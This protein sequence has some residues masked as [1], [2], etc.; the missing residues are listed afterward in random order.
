MFNLKPKTMSKIKYPYSEGDDYWTLEGTDEVYDYNNGGVIAVQSCWDD[1]SEDM[2]TKHLMYFNSLDEILKYS[3]DRFNFVKVS[4]FDSGYP[5]IKT[6][7]YFVVD[8][9][10]GKFKKS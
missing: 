8:L 4:C 9:D 1:Q 10:T 2:H 6:G 3:R 7:D 5:D